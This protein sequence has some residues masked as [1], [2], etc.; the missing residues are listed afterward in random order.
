MHISPL[1]FSVLEHFP[2]S[3]LVPWVRETFP[4]LPNSYRIILY[5]CWLFLFHS[6]FLFSFLLYSC[7]I[8]GASFLILLYSCSIVGAS[9]LILLYSCSIVGASFL[10]L[11]YSCSIVGMLALNSLTQLYRQVGVTCYISTLCRAGLFAEFT[12]IFLRNFV[13]FS[14]F[15]GTVFPCK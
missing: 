8:V 3:D 9:F 12:G 4:I 15:S 5:N 7:S 10:I 11:L 1:I 14:C 2:I 13:V 6:I